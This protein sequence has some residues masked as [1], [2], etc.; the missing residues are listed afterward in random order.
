MAQTN[1]RTDGI[2]LYLA[3]D[4]TLFRKGLIRLIQSFKRIDFIREAANGS[5]LIQLI[6]EQPPD[7]VVV[8]LHMPVMG[9]DEVC[10]WVEENYPDV[11]VIMLTME[12]SDEYVQQLIRLGANAYL[13]K[14]ASPEEVEKAIYSVIDHDFYHNDLVMTALRNYTRVDARI[15]KEPVQFTDRE[16]HIIRLICEERT[17]REIARLLELSEN[18][19]QNY[20]SSIMDKMGVKNTAGLVKYAVIRGIVT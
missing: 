13:S 14:G 7:V 18:T 15:R 12:D 10:R 1:K 11:K 4:H 17:M 20:R 19:V 8:D 6:K 2:T 5:E 3:D 16:M 9:G